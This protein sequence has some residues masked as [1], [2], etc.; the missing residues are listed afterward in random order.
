MDCVTLTIVMEKLSYPR[1]CWRITPS[2][3]PNHKS[4]EV[5]SVEVILGHKMAGYYYQ[6]AAEPILPGQPLLSI[7]E[8]KG[9]L[10]TKGKDLFS[11]ISDASTGNKT[12]LKWGTMLFTAQDLAS[13]LRWRA[14]VNCHDISDGYHILILTSCTGELVYCWGI[15]S[16]L[17][18]Y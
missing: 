15:T 16:V 11:D 10:P 2:Y 7:I 17:H 5:D 14:I 1:T 3:L 4:W 8:P 9:A 18:F 12:I 13:S 6:G